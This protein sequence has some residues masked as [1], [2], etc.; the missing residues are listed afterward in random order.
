[1]KKSF[2]IALIILLLN[3]LIFAE[4]VD[5]KPASPVYPHVLKVIN[6]GIMDT[7][8][9]GKFNGAIS[10]S[11][12]DLAIF[13]S[14]FLDYLDENYKLK[15]ETMDA[16]LSKLLN[17]KLP[18]RVYTLENFI[19]SL[20]TDY[21][22]TK[23]TVSELS[24]DVYYLKQA[25]SINSTE[26]NNPIFKAIAQNASMIAQKK[27]EETI[28]QLYETTLATMITFSNRMDE[29]EK[30]V[31]QLAEEFSKTKEYM[32]NT[33]DDYLNKEK[34]YYKSYIDELFEKEK[35][36][37]KVYIT[38]EISSQ[39]RWKGN[40]DEATI[41]QL[42]NEIN[43]LKN[44]IASSNTYVDDI[45]QQKFDFEVKPL[46][47]LTSK[48]PELDNQIKIL[49]DKITKL[50]TSGVNISN[51]ATLSNDT[52][53]YKKLRDIDMKVNS[54]QSLQIK[55]EELEKAV[56]SYSA[57]LTDTTNRLNNIDNRILDIQKNMSSLKSGN[58]G[59]VPSEIIDRIAVLENRVSNIER[60]ENA[61]DE[62][63]KFSKQ[64]QNFDQRIGLLEGAAFGKE[65]ES[66]SNLFTRLDQIESRINTNDYAVS[67]LTA[68]VLN[69]SKDLDA[70]REAVKASGVKDSSELLK[71]IAEALPKINNIEELSNKNYQDI[72]KINADLKL[73]SELS[74]QVRNLNNIV[75]SLAI[76]PP[77][78]KLQNEV[79]ANSK[80]LFE[81]KS[82][83]DKKSTKIDTLENRLKS[84]EKSIYTLENLPSNNQDA[85][86]NII[87]DMV[88][89][90]LMKKSDDIK[91]YIYMQIKDD[92]IKENMKSLE[93]IVTRLNNLENKVNMSVDSSYL[94]DKIYKI[95]DDIT[96]LKTKN[97][98]L[99]NEILEMKKSEMSNDAL[100]RRLQNLEEQLHS[101]NLMSNVI[102]ALIGGV[103]GGI[104]VY[105]LL[106]GF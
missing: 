37:L 8:T 80:T 27:S 74:E 77:T 85:L 28:K 102:Y 46:M 10:V 1:M 55:V 66:L 76:Q 34:N 31:E 87:D 2:V 56:N 88:S 82:D 19:F 4:L 81:L 69:M 6:A 90:E 52:L 89:Q 16:S 103:V 26:T 36:G 75:Q 96:A 97:N 68:Q 100:N 39:I 20:D 45:I 43:T 17:E 61:A 3:T 33:L 83:F 21:K 99:E 35:T 98:Q 78:Q 48:I 67:N 70:F 63:D 18:D 38:N 60:L 79:I 12:Y 73:V 104:A 49:N 93:A 24:K 58:G 105:I 92:L 65:N 41:T 22:N 64:L 91:N 44:Q 32:I 5:V 51:S 30:S 42:M 53:L 62:I 71:Q 25:I 106:G 59:T 14:K 50:E 23:N 54:L 11:R 95:E 101:Q 9:Q 15:I 13:G 94:G 47:E 57:I 72:Q 84:L 86:I 29:F 7:D 40:T